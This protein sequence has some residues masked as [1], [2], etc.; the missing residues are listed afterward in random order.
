MRRNKILIVD[1]EASMREML[2]DLLNDMDCDLIFAADGKEG[3]DKALDEKPDLILLD[4][5]LPGLDGFQVCSRLRAHPQLAPI[6]VIMVTGHHIEESARRGIEVGAEDVLA[7]PFNI[8]ELKLRVKTVLQL[9]RY[10]LLAHQRS[11]F[12]WVVEHSEDGYVILDKEDRVLYLNPHARGFF[13]MPELERDDA[14]RFF[15][16][17]EG[18]FNCVTEKAWKH[19]PQLRE[20]V[21]LVRPESTNTAALWL[22]VEGVPGMAEGEQ[23]VLR[24]KDVSEGMH[25]SQ[26]MWQFEHMVS[27]KMHAPLMGLLG[28]LDALETGGDLLNGEGRVSLLGD[29]SRSAQCLKD[30]VQG[31]LDHIGSRKHEQN[32][33]SGIGPE[34][35]EHFA[36]QLALTHELAS[37][38]FDIEPGL[39]LRELRLSEEDA[40]LMLQELFTNSVKF[41]PDGEPSVELT[42]IARN[43]AMATLRIMDDGQC[44][45][46]A[47]IDKIGTP[48]YQVSNRSVSEVPG[49]GLGLSMIATLVAS[50]GGACR[51]ENRDDKPGLVVE[52]DIPFAEL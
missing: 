10:R 42:L 11:Q 9:N 32:Q 47:V 34:K 29:A 27:H 24:L 48:F 45:D 4:I 7:K 2:G 8:S 6:P 33:C 52:L 43:E 31:V 36:G 28:T 50:C 51:I 30:A 22:S 21:F 1:D 18:R 35:L 20:K 37:L 46:P 40:L 39:L 16:L 12:H 49:M 5:M 44:L 25:V 3:F 14:V 17:V 38:K 15:E 26:Q 13:K 19:W 41:H 23:R